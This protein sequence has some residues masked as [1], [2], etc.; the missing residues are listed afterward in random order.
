MEGKK[1]SAV[2]PVVVAAS[3][4]S[5]SRIV[6]NTSSTAA[7]N[8]VPGTPQLLK[9]TDTLAIS[10]FADLFGFPA[11]AVLAAV[12]MNR[13]AIKQAYYSIPELALRWRM[14]RAGVYNVLRE[15]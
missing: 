12:E 9:E 11:S 2:V 8:I 6:S 7:R 5:P 3:A 4:P 14:S 1:V 10:E 15:T 13:R